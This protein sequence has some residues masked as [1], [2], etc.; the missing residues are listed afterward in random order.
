M[1][2][3][4]FDTRKKLSSIIINNQLLLVGRIV[5]VIVAAWA[6]TTGTSSF[7]LFAMFGTLLTALFR[8]FLHPE[9]KSPNGREKCDSAWVWMDS[10]CSHSVACCG[11]NCA[12]IGRILWTPG[13]TPLQLLSI[14]VY[15]AESHPM[16]HQ[17]RP[18]KSTSTLM[19]V[20][21]IGISG[22]LDRHTTSHVASEVLMRRLVAQVSIE[23]CCVVCTSNL[24]IGA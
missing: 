11:V 10:N 19:W 7:A 22:G 16:I 1:A 2:N 14:S 24:H 23:I 15:R 6:I 18:I 21:C 9:K 4:S 8:F 12:I 13:P 17:H 5:V 3:Y 20:K